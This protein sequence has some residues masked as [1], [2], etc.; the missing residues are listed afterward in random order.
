MKRLFLASLVSATLIGCGG[1]DGGSPDPE[2]EKPL[3]TKPNDDVDGEMSGVFPIFPLEPSTQIPTTPCEEGM[4]CMDDGFTN[5]DLPVVDSVKAFADVLHTTEN[6]IRLLCDSSWFACG[7]ASDKQTPI[8]FFSGLAYVP[9][10]GEL[11]FQTGFNNLFQDDIYTDNVSLTTSFS[12]I[13]D[14]SE[15]VMIEAD[16]VTYQLTTNVFDDPIYLM[17]TKYTMD[18]N[19]W[20][21]IEG[22]YATKATTVTLVTYENGYQDKDVHYTSSSFDSTAL[23]DPEAA[24]VFRELANYWTT[25]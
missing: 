6:K 13:T 12:G 22:G 3:P 20:K 2:V 9:T 4:D 21:L 7:V 8:L 17:T 10:A 14:Y 1:S 15:H 5:P 23:M 11:Y 16:G 24:E 19:N 18:Y 25:Q